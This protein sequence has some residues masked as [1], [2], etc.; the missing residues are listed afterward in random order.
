MRPSSTPVQMFPSASTTT[1]SGAFPGTETTVRSA[2]GKSGNGSTGGGC[3]RT[4]STGGLVP[5]IAA[6][7]QVVP[8]PGQD[9]AQ[10]PF[11]LVKLGLA[12]DQR[13]RQLDYR[14]AAVVGSAVKARLEQL[15]R[16]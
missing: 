16:Q 6:S 11:D 7:L 1:S 10:N 15:G 2:G 8:G 3:Q 12:A 13:R 5:G 4:G 9:A 14:I